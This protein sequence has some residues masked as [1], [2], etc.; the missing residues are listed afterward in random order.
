MLFMRGGSIDALAM[1]DKFLLA[2]KKGE[3]EKKM[4]WHSRNKLDIKV[5]NRE[6]TSSLK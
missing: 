4:H 1:K 3:T 6:I 2:G 5:N